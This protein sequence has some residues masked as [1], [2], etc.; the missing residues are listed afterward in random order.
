MELP[1]L[2]ELGKIKHRIDI[3]GIVLVEEA[4]L[5][6]AGYDGIFAD[7]DE[8]SPLLKRNNFSPGCGFMRVPAHRIYLP[9]QHVV[10]R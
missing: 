7:A 4:V 2:Q 1:F 9:F 3:V 5:F 8:I 10:I 6:Q